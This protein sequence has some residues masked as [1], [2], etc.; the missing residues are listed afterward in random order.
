MSALP[1]VPGK[2]LAANIDVGTHLVR[3]GLN[4]DTIWA[5]AVAGAIVMGMGLYLKRH[6]T[7]GVPG[8]LQLLWEM[9][10]QA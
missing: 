4:L 10:V 3:A 2:L 7:A 1:A 5:T 8:K 9:V 6:A